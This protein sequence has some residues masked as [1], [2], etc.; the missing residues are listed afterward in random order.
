MCIFKN[1]IKLFFLKEIKIFK[2]FLITFIISQGTS[3]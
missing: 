2:N 3:Y 1:D